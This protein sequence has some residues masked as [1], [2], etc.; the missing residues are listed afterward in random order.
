MIRSRK[1]ISIVLAFGLCVSL[2]AQNKLSE[3]RVY[4]LDATYSMVSPSKLWDPV[5]KDL[6]KAINAIEDP[7]TEIYVIAFGGNKGEELKS[8][9]GFA[10][11]TDKQ[12]IIT[13][14]Q[15]FM[16]QR[17]TM[18]YLDKPLNDFCS[19]KVDYG[20]VTYCFLM[21]DGQDERP[22]R[23][24]YGILDKW[25]SRYGETN[26]YGFYVMLNKEAKD[27]KIDEI[28]DR[29]AHLWKVET[30][31]VNIN[32][33][34]LDNKA[35]F[36]VKSDSY[37]EIPISG[38][39]SGLNFKAVFPEDCGLNAKSCSL[40]EGK[41]LVKVNVVGDKSKMPESSSHDLIITMN[42]GGQFDFLVTDKVRVKCSNKRERI[43]RTPSDVRQ[44]GKVK[45]YDSFLFVPA[46]TTPAKHTI[47]FDFNEDAKNDA[48]TYAVLKFVDRKGNLINSN[49]MKIKVNGVEVKNN[50]F[51]VTPSDNIAE[52]EVTFANKAK[53]GRYKGYLRLASNNLH[54]LNN[55][56]CNGGTIDACAW[57]VQ[58]RKSMNPLAAILMWLGIALA[59]S[60]T[61]WFAILKPQRYPKFKK[62]RKSVLIKKNGVVVSNF[63]T[64]F[65]GAREVW[66][67]DKKMKQSALNKIFTGKIIT[68]VNPNFEQPIRFVSR[69]NGK[70][71]MGIGQGY[72]FNP[73]PLLQSGVATINEPVKKLT[74]Y[75]Q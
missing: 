3:R 33:I 41:L 71:A 36:N 34:R 8:W 23:P 39:T 24:F 19:G 32:L 42:G 54:R 30:A 53:L 60:L 57:S 64:D 26:V 10:T 52:I 61:I 68:V 55:D 56:E 37:I 49:D 7:N 72:T 22:N 21:T 31:D 18:T 40:S 44:F 12:K 65:K 35:A 43:L 14:F 46:S 63:T 70:K 58:N 1:I 51:K 5:R 59:A 69:K 38:K 16:P 62:F 20:K 11:D 15:S 25:G 13:G 73:N 17:N 45:H 29:Q 27:S 74:I 6:A 2:S 48:S 66:F 75:L 28:V 9:H 47:Q 50:S 4:Y 67:S